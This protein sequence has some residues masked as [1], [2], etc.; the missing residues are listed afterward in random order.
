MW[1]FLWKFLETQA[2]AFGVLRMVAWQNDKKT[3]EKPKNGGS[4]HGGQISID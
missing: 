1:T 4:L 2:K 3:P